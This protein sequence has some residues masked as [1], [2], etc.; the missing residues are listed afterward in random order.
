MLGT[1]IE[2]SNTPGDD[3][4]LGSTSHPDEHPLQLTRAH[5]LE[6]EAA[7]RAMGDSPVYEVHDDFIIF[8]L[9]GIAGGGA[10]SDAGDGVHD[11]ACCIRPK[12][13]FD[14]RRA[15]MQ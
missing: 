7:I 4:P 15:L 1:H 2:M 3:F 13:V 9:G 8:P 14:L 10:R 11:P 12:S 6:L 5:L